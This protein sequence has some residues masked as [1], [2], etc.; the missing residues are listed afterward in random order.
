MCV[1]VGGVGATVKGAELGIRPWFWQEQLW[2]LDVVVEGLRNS[3]GRRG[4]KIGELE[5]WVQLTPRR[6]QLH[7]SKRR[8]SVHCGMCVGGMKLL[9]IGGA[10][11]NLCGNWN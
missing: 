4:L 1:R 5:G 2:S 8:F 10:D 3:E 9:G 11:V 7:R 6:R